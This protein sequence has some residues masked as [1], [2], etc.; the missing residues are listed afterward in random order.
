VR[1]SS[2]SEARRDDDGP[3]NRREELEV[4]RVRT[5]ELRDGG[6]SA[7]GCMCE[8]EGGAGRVVRSSS[9]AIRVGRAQDA[10]A[11]GTRTATWICP[12]QAVAH[13][14]ASSQLLIG[15]FGDSVES[16]LRVGGVSCVHRLRF[17]VL[18]TR[19]A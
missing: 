8:R 10:A 6:G 18:A 4:S 9:S 2:R 16:R 7:R 13:L 11:A 12:E 3:D 19:S 14:G 15:S 17:G 5:G 1:R